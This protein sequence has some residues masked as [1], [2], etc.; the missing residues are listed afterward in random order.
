[1]SEPTIKQLA[2]AINHNA[3]LLEKHLGEGVYVHQQQTPST[4]W[5]ITHSLG[6]LRPLIETYDSAGNKIGHAVNRQTQTFEYC[7]IVFIVPMS[8]TAILRF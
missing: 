6:S 2:E 8:G 3:G 5:K 7:E 4:S 1:M